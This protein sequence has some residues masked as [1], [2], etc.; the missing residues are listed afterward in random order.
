VAQISPPLPPS[1]VQ[2]RLDERSQ[3]APAVEWS[4]LE[5]L[6]HSL[7][8]EEFHK[9]YADFYAA[10][11]VLPPPWEVT[12]EQLAVKTGTTAEPV[13]NIKFRTAGDPLAQSERYWRTPAELPA[14]EGKPVLTGLRIA[15]DAGHIGGEYAVMEERQLSLQPGQTVR[16]GECTLL[17][18]KLLKTKLEALGA[19]VYLV[20]GEN[21]PVTTARPAD[22]RAEAVKLLSNSGITSPQDSY[23]GLTA[24]AKV[25]TVQWQAEKLFYRV[26]E[27][28]ARAGKVNQQYKPDVV[29]CLHLNAEPWGD[30]AE[31]QPS[32]NNH[33]HLLINGCYA[34]YELML[35]DERYEML[36]RLFQRI[37]EEELPLAESL[38]Q[39]MAKHTGLPAFDYRVP[40]QARR[41]GSTGYVWARNL[42]ANRLY[43]CPVIYLEPYVM[44]HAETFARLVLGHYRGKTLV[45]GKLQRSIYEDYVSGVV[46]GL[47]NYYGEKRGS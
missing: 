33:L 14:L 12:A 8:E 3:L 35:Q 45:G 28:R 23:A 9:V 26:S 37:H 24:D 13:V 17:V 40:G 11:K 32:P 19:E 5:E 39:S 44:N 31:P 46:E 41:V 36:Q 1:E 2:E 7:T 27:I 43:Q 47:V 20:R 21:A 22:L 4:K 25:T 29:L 15:L 42:L 38:A 30:G 16:E 10:D 34:P 18:A 6:S